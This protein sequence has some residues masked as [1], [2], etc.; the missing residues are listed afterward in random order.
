MLSKYAVGPQIIK[1]KNFNKMSSTKMAKIGMNFS[2]ILPG[3]FVI[4]TSYPIKNNINDCE[5]V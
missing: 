1:Q 2:K 5:V 3:G 4:S